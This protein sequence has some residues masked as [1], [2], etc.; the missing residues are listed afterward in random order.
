MTFLYELGQRLGL[1]DQFRRT[2]DA[3]LP[4]IQEIKFKKPLRPVQGL[5]ELE[6]GLGLT[7][8]DGDAPYWGDA[9][10]MWSVWWGKQSYLIDTNGELEFILSPT[11]TT[12][13]GAERSADGYSRIFT[14]L[15]AQELQEELNR[16]LP[17]K[18]GSWFEPRETFIRELH[19]TPLLPQKAK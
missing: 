11:M 4:T 8:R 10:K 7:V 19:L 3:T 12:I 6:A 16:R 5:R 17:E 2:K 15:S 13:I 18:M 9:I 14:P 1:G